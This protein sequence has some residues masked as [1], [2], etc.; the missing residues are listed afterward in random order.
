M[1]YR[2][3]GISFGAQITS[4]IDYSCVAA[5]WGVIKSVDKRVGLGSN[6]GPTPERSE[7]GQLRGGDDRVCGQSM[8]RYPAV[9]SPRRLMSVFAESSPL[10]R[11]SSP[12]VSARA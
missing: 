6:I 7:A 8:A 11:R 1:M 3:L 9:P 2:S 5:G 10:N 4:T 12:R